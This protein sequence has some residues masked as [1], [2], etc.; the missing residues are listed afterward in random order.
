MVPKSIL[1]LYIL[2]CP[3]LSFAQDNNLIFSR[4][5]TEDG[6]S[7]SWV[8]CIYQDAYGFIWFGTSDGLNRYDGY[9]IKE[10]KSDE[11]NP[12]AIVNA[13]INYIDRREDGKLWICTERGVDIF[14]RDHDVFIDFPY[15]DKIRVTHVLTDY[16]KKTW[17]SS[18]SGLYCYDPEDSTIV[19]ITNNPEDS[20]T[21]SHN[22]V[23]MTYEDSSNNLWI[24]TRNG[25]NLYDRKNQ[26]F[27]RYASSGSPSS[28]SGNYIRSIVEDKE[29]RL[30]VGNQD[31]GVDLFIN[32]KEKP[33]KGIFRNVVS[34]STSHMMID[35]RGFL[36]IGH[37][38][39]FG[40]NVLDLN[41]FTQDG[42]NTIYHYDYLPY[43]ERS[44]SDDAI[45][46]I[47]EDRDKGIWVGTYAGGV[48]YYSPRTKKFESVGHIPGD[49]QSLSDNIVNCFLEDKDFFWV[50]TENGLCR[51]DRRS[52]V[53][54]NYFYEPEN[55]K[56]LGANG[57]ICIDKDKR[58]NIWIGTWNGGLNLYNYRQNNFTRYLPNEDV[59]G[60]I[61]NEHVFA[62]LEDSRGILWVGTNG[63]GL[64]TYDYKTKKFSYYLPDPNDLNSL[65]HN[66][67]NDIC[68]TSNGELYISTYHS[69]D[70]F[71]Y[72]TGTFSHFVCDAQDS[73]SISDGNLLDIFEDSKQNLWIGT[74]RGLNYF[75]RDKNIFRH[76]TT[77][78]GLPSNTIQAILEDDKGNLWLSTNN[79]I[80]KFIDGTELPVK[81][82]FRSYFANDG[83]QGNEFVR[84]S[85]LKSNSGI[86]YF[87]G[88]KGYTYFNP[89]SIA[90]NPIPPE[91]VLID[92]Q[93]FGN[94]DEESQKIMVHGRDINLAEEIVLS[95]D[96]SDFIIKYSALNY[97][98]SDRNQYEYML[99]GY[100]K[101]WHSV[102]TQR[103]ATYT[104]IHPGKYTFMVR[105][106]N[107]DGVWSEKAKTLHI[108]IKPP[109]WKT[110]AFQVILAFLIISIIVGIYRIRFALLERQKH[111]LEKMVKER[112]G[113]LSELN[114]LLGERQEEI[115]LQNK[116][117]EK[118]RNHLEQLVAERT[119][120]LD[121]AREI[122]E[123]SDN[124]KSAFL[125]N[126]S[127]EI[128]TPM[129][130]IVGFASML[131]DEDIKHEEKEEFI[132]I[133][134]S[135]SQTL[136]VLI[137][138]ILEISLI[139]VNQLVLSKE[140]FNAIKVL[141]ELESYFKLKNHKKLD[142]KFIN[143]KSK[144][145]LTLN[146]DQTRFRQIVSNLLSNSYKYTD[147]GS[148][149]FGFEILDNQVQFCIADT[150]IGINESEYQRIFD[151]FHKIDKGDNKLY[152]G[153]GIGLSI[154]NKLVELM[155]G[156][157]WLESK[158]DKGTTFYFT[159]PYPGEKALTS[160]SSG[161]KTKAKIKYNMAG[162]TILIAEDELANFQLLN[163]VFKPTRA[164]VLWA[165]NGKEAV[166]IVRENKQLNK[167][168]VLMDIKMP[169]MNGITA[170]EEI[171]KI[172]KDIPVIAV[173]AYAQSGDKKE[174]LRHGFVDYMAK[175]LKSEKLLEIIYN[176]L[177]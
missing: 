112:T 98:N 89:D 148:I 117:L 144:T 74:T 97:L 7:S 23:E 177:K 9:E 42:K 78:D 133:I 70:L 154:S 91:I 136:L 1:I 152:R 36:W 108:I 171:K 164:K 120:Q 21:L 86:V 131:K 96:Q 48:N 69:L 104:N 38:L 155:G 158:V 110:I 167:F 107:N 4:I 162:A 29:G 53:F 141:E 102:G 113:E 43:N 40:V 26:S 118:H 63:G 147:S 85:A 151:Y 58:G 2:V 160:S 60:S 3:V 76:Y 140:P 71:D 126:M 45:Y 166:Q 25:L 92:F 6:L 34:G 103:T 75:N 84:R 15:L 114:A 67:V 150:G 145:R 22:T 105:G 111:M 24:G 55:P 138:D 124:L 31:Y 30:W 52:G 80:S 64:N 93:L 49:N 12:N 57:V 41:A 172:N 109:W 175:P 127:H 51:L 157:I 143:K 88:S 132:D 99:D 146:H 77:K 10:Y 122:A 61:S 168:I 66:A 134:T 125:A 165:K 142:I 32:A 73:N 139:E 20:S 115:S 50:G 176:L 35:S 174:I 18:Y 83:L 27:K 14:D 161:E 5:T 28:L 19:L 54:T 46:Y 44:L 129:N 106:S 173:T 130:A 100:E 33:D 39:G 116:E 153:A 37:G 123:A 47:F 163:R 62:V 169:V 72:N 56:S 101:N 159:L 11:S 13:A 156:K 8:R 16:E 68:E 128:R 81:P 59:S 135:N 149:H 79:G 90:E 121:E 95:F 65:Y 170:N 119:E 82:E 17:F 137:N 94:S 87:G